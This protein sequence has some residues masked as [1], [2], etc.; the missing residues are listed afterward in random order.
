MARPRKFNREDVLAKAMETFWEKGFQA[1]TLDDLVKA[2]GLE[3]PSLY[4][5]FGN[6]RQLYLEA[7]DHYG[8][9][10]YSAIVKMLHRVTAEES[11]LVAVR[12]LFEIV[13]EKVEKHK[14]H[15]GCF[16]F[17]TSVEQ[18]PH[19]PS[20]KTLIHKYSDLLRKALKNILQEDTSIGP[21]LNKEDTIALADHFTATL[22]GLY[23]FAKAG[24][25]A[26]TLRNVAR[27]ALQPLTNPE[28]LGSVNPSLEKD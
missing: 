8:L 17:N 12:A 11:A 5:T 4:N 23:T 18:A 14:D 15:R 3:R 9:E 19:D 16:L 20:V 10:E 7:I 1:T 24:Y 28:L 26:K 2:T 6:K 13:V 25:K 21:Y 27:M 22:M